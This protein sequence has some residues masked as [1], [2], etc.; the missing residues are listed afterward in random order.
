[1]IQFNKIKNEYT[2]KYEYDK[3]RET[4]DLYLKSSNPDMYYYKLFV[5]GDLQCETVDSKTVKCLDFEP[6]TYDIWITGQTETCNDAL[7]EIKLKIPKYNKM[8]EDP[9]CEGIEEFVLCNPGYEKEIDYNSFVSRINT[10]KKNKQ[11]NEEE[12]KEEKKDKKESIIDEK[13]LNFLKNNIIE[14]I[15]ISIFIILVII[16]AIVTIKSMRK[17]R[18]LE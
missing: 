17:S 15:V 6:G 16:T 12:V 8:S 3:T 4:Y 9:L 13:I 18:R 5:T 14:I 10:Y 11:Q 7:K 2:V 1:M